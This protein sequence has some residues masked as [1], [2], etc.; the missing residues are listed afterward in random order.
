MEGNKKIWDP[1]KC[2]ESTKITGCNE[3]MRVGR[4]SPELRRNEL[5]VKVKHKSDFWRC[6][7]LAI[8][9]FLVVLPFLDPS[10]PQLP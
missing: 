9:S 5:E 7:K 2:S 3:Q 6:P 10:T 8:V 4:C 1:K